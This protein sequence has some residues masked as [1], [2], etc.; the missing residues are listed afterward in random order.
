M[1]PMV[2]E[3]DGN[4]EIGAHVKSNISFIWLD[5]EQSQIDIV[6]SEKSLFPSYEHNILWVTI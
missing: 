2:L 4:T 3:L 5:R 6:S 1:E